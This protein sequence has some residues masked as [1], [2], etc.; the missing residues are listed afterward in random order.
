MKKKTKRRVL[1][2]YLT[3]ERNRAMVEMRKRGLSFYNIAD[4]FGV[5]RQYVAEVF[6]LYGKIK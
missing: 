4:I 5:S 2:P 1:E 3:S 6:E